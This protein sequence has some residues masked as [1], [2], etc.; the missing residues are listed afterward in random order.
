[1]S[2]SKVHSYPH[3]MFTV[4]EVEVNSRCNRKCSYCP[5]SI[6]P[7]PDVPR[8]MSEEVFQRLLSELSRIKF[9]GRMSYHF[10]NEPLLRTD[11]EEL[12][13]RCSNRLP[14]AHQVLYTNGDL[15]TDDRY[16]RLEKAGIAHFIVTSHDSLSYP[17]RPKQTILFP[18]DLK[19]T[20][21]GGIMFKLSDPLTLACYAPSEML[22]VTVTG[23]VVLCYEDA[24]R[25]QVMGNIV[26]SPLEEIWFSVEFVRLR[27][28]L[29]NGRRGQGAAICKGC[30]N[31]AHQAL[32][33]SWFAL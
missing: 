15:L 21:R 28:L 23:D 27:N 8:L 18:S 4:V 25:T 31:N 5:V 32:G 17:S 14:E 12:I 30:D 7:V 11:L 16:L 10:Y 29:A 33:D 9:S 3:E 24:K 6:L 2:D 1:M 22:I 26:S 19:L 20:D 13:E